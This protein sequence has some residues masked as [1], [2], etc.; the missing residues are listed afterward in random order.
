MSTLRKA[1]GKE[2]KARRKAQGL[3]LRALSAKAKV[4]LGFLSEIERGQKEV[5]SELLNAILEALNTPLSEVVLKAGASIA[6]QERN[7]VVVKMPVKDQHR[8]A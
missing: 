7:A 6:A 4:S 5:S 3:S 2:L 1:L 8:A